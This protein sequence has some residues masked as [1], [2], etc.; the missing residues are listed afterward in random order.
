MGS[1]IAEKVK[2]VK[3]R[4]ADA[5][6]LSVSMSPPSAITSSI[7]GS[8]LIFSDFIPAGTEVSVSYSCPSN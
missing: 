4:C 2:E 8:T 5:S 7:S 3:L 6:D 1:S